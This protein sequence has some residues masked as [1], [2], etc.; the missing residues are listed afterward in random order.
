MD[1]SPY[2]QVHETANSMSQHRVTSSRDCG[3]A[4]GP[5]FS[6]RNINRL[7]A[8]ASMGFR[9]DTLSQRQVNGDLQLSG[10]S[11]RKSAH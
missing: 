4:G 7:G 3:T 6:R 9:F 10:E 8:G 2:H 1:R 5:M 11:N